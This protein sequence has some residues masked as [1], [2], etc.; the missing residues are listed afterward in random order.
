M[1]PN[2]NKNVKENQM[3]NMIESKLDTNVNIKKNRYLIYDKLHFNMLFF[4][5]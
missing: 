4:F 1:Y 3:S 5:V 2:I